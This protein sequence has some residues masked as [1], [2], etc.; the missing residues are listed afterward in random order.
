MLIARVVKVMMEKLPEE[1]EKLCEKHDP[2]NKREK[3][4]KASTNTR[5]RPCH[6]PHNNDH[7]ILIYLLGVIRFLATFVY[8]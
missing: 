8:A 3:E 4:L 5:R 7:L 2:G 1:W 6:S